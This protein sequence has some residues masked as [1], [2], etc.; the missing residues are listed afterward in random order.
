MPD[1]PNTPPRGLRTLLAAFAVALTTAA[2]ACSGG[3]AAPP[4]ATETTSTSS[5]TTTPT[6]TATPSPTSTTTTPSCADLLASRLTPAQRVGQ[7]VMVGLDSGSGR[8]ALDAEIQSLHLGGVLYL[9]G[10][11][12][13]AK[14]KATSAHLQSQTGRKATGG[15]R[16]LIAADQEGGQVQ[17]LE[18]DGFSAIPSALR[19]GALSPTA[20]QTKATSWG[21]ELVRVGVN[22]NLAPVADTVPTALGADNRPIGGFDREY[23]HDPAQVSRA[24]VAVVKGLH[25]AGVQPT[26]KHFPGLGRIQNNTDVSASG[27]TDSVTTMS[28][29]Y[30][31]PFADGIDAGTGLVMVSLARYSRLDP[32]NQAV[33]SPTIITGLLRDRLGYDGVVISDDLGKARA[34]S[35]VA[36][37]TRAVRFIGA[38]GDLV[39]TAA[40]SRARAMVT[41][42][43]ARMARDRAFAAKVETSVRRVLALKMQ[44]GLARC[45]G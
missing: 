1:R 32:Q 22:V 8:T 19:Q 23:G 17:Q 12:G 5:T 4:A 18:G 13:A 2:A 38:G 9:G 33:F 3:R 37:G 6:T 14:V 36:P 27:I 7:L 29:R 28:D 35:A 10:W 31:E 42:V 16:L 39:I 24:V 25:E 21:R 41:A 11:S 26:V 45:G 40:P 30:L 20:L 43:T 34:V 15:V 44:M